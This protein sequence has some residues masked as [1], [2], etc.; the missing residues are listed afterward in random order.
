MYNTKTPLFPDSAFALR[1]RD[2]GARLAVQ[3]Y[4]EDHVGADDFLG[5][6]DYC[7]AGL[8]AAPNVAKVVKLLLGPMANSAESGE[9]ESKSV[10]C[11]GKGREGDVVEY[12]GFVSVE[13]TFKPNPIGIDGVDIESLAKG[14]D[15][16]DDGDGVLDADELR[17][18][19]LRLAPEPEPED[20]EA[21]D[22]LS[23]RDE[24]ET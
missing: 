23:P 5:Q 14:I 9:A 24:M 12:T 15:A 22:F 3:A 10:C 8:I 19:V 20:P 17:Q 13:L 11:R 21:G 7:V 16:D 2:V 18:A 1:V 4:D 6:G